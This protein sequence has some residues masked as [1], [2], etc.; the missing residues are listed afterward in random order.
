MYQSWDEHGGYQFMLNNRRDQLAAGRPM[1]QVKQTVDGTWTP[2]AAADAG[3]W[4]L[5]MEAK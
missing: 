1:P 4:A 3:D 5:L 2:P